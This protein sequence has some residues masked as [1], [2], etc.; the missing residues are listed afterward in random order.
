MDEVWVTDCTHL[1]ID[2]CEQRR[3]LHFLQILQELGSVSLLNFE[4]GFL[5]NVFSSFVMSLFL[6][7]ILYAAI[8][9]ISPTGFCHTILDS[10]L[11]LVMSRKGT[12]E[13]WNI[14]AFRSNRLLNFISFR[15]RRCVSFINTDTSVFPLSRWLIPAA[16]VNGSAGTQWFSAT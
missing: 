8:Y 13:L 1:A 16:L 10:S 11:V 7:L 12:S 6:L 2:H 15:W 14:F 3:V 4:L 9:R 5:C